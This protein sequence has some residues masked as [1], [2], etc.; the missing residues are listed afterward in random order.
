MKSQ[1]MSLPRLD[2]NKKADRMNNSLL[3][4]SQ[5]DPYKVY[6][7]DEYRPNAKYSYRHFKVRDLQPSNTLKQVKLVNSKQS[8]KEILPTNI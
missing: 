7:K 6:E 2:I 3:N 1:L 5:D 8:H 4:M